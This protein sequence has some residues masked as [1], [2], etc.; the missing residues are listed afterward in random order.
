MIR[1]APMTGALPAGFAAL[2]AEA[3]AEGYRMLDRLAAEWCSGENRFDRPGEALLAAY[4]GQELAGIGGVTLEPALAGAVR[5][6]RFYVRMA[7][8][9]SGVARGLAHTLLQPMQAGQCVT[10]NAGRGSEAFWEALGFA[11][12][13]TAGTWTHI[14]LGG[15]RRMG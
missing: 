8:R 6:R 3:R 2:R 4:A 1:L 13:P 14:S 5:M 9:R 11:R 10:V 12:D 15:I 7:F